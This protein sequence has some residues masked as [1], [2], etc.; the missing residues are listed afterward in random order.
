M[1]E[2]VKRTMGNELPPDLERLAALIE[3]QPPKVREAFH[4]CL[5]VALEESGKAK[6][7]NTAQVDG[8]TYYSYK[9]I[10]GDVFTVVRPDIDAG[11]EKAI[12]RELVGILEEDGR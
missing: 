12:R 1:P 8:R 9:T 3:Q 2:E 7:I 11:V 5:A 4:F 6:L 10:A